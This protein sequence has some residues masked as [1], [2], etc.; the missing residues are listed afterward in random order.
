[1]NGESFNRE[2]IHGFVKKQRASM[3]NR[4]LVGHVFVIVDGDEEGRTG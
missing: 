1:V 4:E 2:Q 3:A